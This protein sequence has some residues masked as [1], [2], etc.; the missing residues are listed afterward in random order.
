L[1]HETAAAVPMVAL[2]AVQ[3]LLEHGR[4]ERGQTVL[5]L[6]AGGGVGSFAV[7]V[8]R[9]AGARV[10]AAAR[11]WARDLVRELGADLFIDVD[12]GGLEDAARDAD[13]V[14]DLVG[15][16]AHARASAAVK[17]GGALVSAVEQPPETGGRAERRV[18]FVVEPNREQLAAVGARI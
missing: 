9:A 7:Q 17:A 2:T 10:I 16:E 12:Q 6:G 11:G 4:L 13:L 1:D 8:A 15:G 3:A 18:F 5:I 14:F